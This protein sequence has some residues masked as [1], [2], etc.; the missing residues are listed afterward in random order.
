MAEDPTAKLTK[1]DRDILELASRGLTDKQIADELGM[2]RGTVIG[3]WVRIRLKLQA[4]SRTEAVAFSQKLGAE[5][6]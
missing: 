1:R 3:Y 6:V 2:G 4:S 5:G